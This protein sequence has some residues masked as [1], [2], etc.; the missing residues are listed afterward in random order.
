MNP[1]TASIK[2]KRGMSGSTLKLIA[3]ITMLIDHTAATILQRLIV[4][5]QLGMDLSN[6]QSVMDFYAHNGVLLACYSIMRLIGRLGFPLFCFLLV[7]GFQHTRNVW[8][9][10]GRLAVFALI[11]EIPFDLALF[12]HPFYW[13]NQNVFFTLFAGLLVLIGFKTISEKA[14]DK[15]WLPLVSIAGAVAAGCAAAYAVIEIIHAI[16][17]LLI[18]VG[19]ELTIATGNVQIICSILFSIIAFTI[20]GIMCRKNSF[21]KASVRFADVALL[22]AGMTA[23]NLLKTD[24]SAF[25]V[26]TIAVMYALRK[27][28]FKAM[29][30]GCVTLTIMSFSEI[31]CF[32]TLIPAYLYNGKRG[33]NLKYVFYLF[34]PVHLFL[35]YLICYFMKIV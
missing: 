28:P 22:V 10:A 29:L 23:A 35:L 25:G 6:T 4:Q 20:Y 2:Q 7:E 3:I 12:A 24:Y 13:D 15:K 26:L 31:T 8:K 27:K 17:S 14:A 34:Y 30:G 1:E 18:G 5:G 32:F 33:M 19:S 9:Y 16:N 21:M 11:S